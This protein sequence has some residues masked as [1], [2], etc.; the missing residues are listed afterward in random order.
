MLRKHAC[1]VLCLIFLAA[2]GFCPL[3]VFKLFF[4]AFKNLS[5]LVFAFK[6]VYFSFG[7]DEILN[8]C[9]YTPCCVN[10]LALCFVLFFLLPWDSV[11]CFLLASFFN[12]L[13]VADILTHLF[14]PLL[15]YVLVLAMI[16]YFPYT[17]E[18][19]VCAHII[20]ISLFSLEDATK[21]K[22]VYLVRSRNLGILIQWIRILR[23]KHNHM[24]DLEQIRTKYHRFRSCYL[25]MQEIKSDTGLGWNEE[26]QTIKCDEDQ[27]QRFCKVIFLHYKNVLSH[28]IVT[29]LVILS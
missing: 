27:W 23:A 9:H 21:M 8:I 6:A 1:I 20:A 5:Q 2:I 13:W 24:C 15:L 18:P 7:D 3:F 19:H 4:Q 16:K 22:Y 17:L 26:K 14:L 28:F 11:R 25:F 29:R 12:I 10:I